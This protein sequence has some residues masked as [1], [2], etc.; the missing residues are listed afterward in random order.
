MPRKK[1]TI[2]AVATP[3]NN[4]SELLEIFRALLNG[5]IAC[6]LFLYGKPGRGKSCAALA[7]TDFVP[8]SCYSTDR[9]LHDRMTQAKTRKLW[10]ESGRVISLA[11]AWEQWRRAELA[12]L[13]ELTGNLWPYQVGG[14]SREYY[15]A[16]MQQALDDRE[17]VALIVIS[18]KEATQIGK[19][20]GEHIA[21]RL[22]AGTQFELTGVDRRRR[23]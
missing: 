11:E 10:D 21:S 8:R 20:L 14:R 3:D 6:P 4:G 2:S 12:V 5:F 15:A 13:D 17:G 23:R 22:L 16:V 1:R 7:L 9:K 19:D 18:N